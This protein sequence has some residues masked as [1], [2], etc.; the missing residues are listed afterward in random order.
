[1]VPR[2]KLRDAVVQAVLDR[3]RTEGLV[4]GDALPPERVLAVELGVSR[5]VVREGLTSLEMQGVLELV[6]GRKPV[7]VRRFERAFAETLGHAV[8]QD[9]AR[10]GEL[11]EVRRIV[12]PEAAA[13][14]AVRATAEELAA[15]QRA[16]DEMD[17]HLDATEGY[18]DAD[19]AFHEALLSAS[20]N[21]LL[22]EMLRPAAGLLVESRRLSVGARR[23]PASALDEHRRILAAIRAGDPAVA[24]AAVAEHL[25]ATALD[26]AASADPD[27]VVAASGSSQER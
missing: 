16:V 23:P 4:P 13:L 10:L 14:A 27:D 19:V 2:G 5:T 25:S 26:L 17:A 9:S 11:L 6:P 8:G 24:R 22:A 18:V 20:G 3:I 12:E 1:M 7:V 15:M 21:Q